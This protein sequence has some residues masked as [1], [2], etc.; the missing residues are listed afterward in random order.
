MYSNLLE[1]ENEP[2]TKGFPLTDF[3]NMYVSFH[4]PIRNGLVPTLFVWSQKS[5]I[6]LQT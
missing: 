6:D 2:I 5:V 1:K 4:Y 3:I